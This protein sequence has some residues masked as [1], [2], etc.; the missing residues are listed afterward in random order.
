MC[1]YWI[2]KYNITNQLLIDVIMNFINKKNFVNL[3]NF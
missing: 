2:Y 1:C 3:F